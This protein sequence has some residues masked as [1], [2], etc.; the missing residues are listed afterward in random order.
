[1]ITFETKDLKGDALDWAVKYVELLILAMDK[2]RRR[3]FK[4]DHDVALEI[5]N[6]GNTEI[7]ELNAERIMHMVKS[8]RIAAF[9]DGDWFATKSDDLT[10]WSRDQDGDIAHVMIYE[11]ETIRGSTYEEAIARCYVQ[12]VVGNTIAIPY[13][14]V[15]V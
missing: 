13:K 7:P 3:P 15:K 6:M 8:E 9:E 12:S 4:A 2:T 1:M 11:A 14:L 5:I 10:T